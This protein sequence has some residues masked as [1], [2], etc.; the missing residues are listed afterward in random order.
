MSSLQFSELQGLKQ[1]NFYINNAL[2]HSKYIPVLNTIC[3]PNVVIWH[4]YILY[5][6]FSLVTLNSRGRITKADLCLLEPSNE[7][8]INRGR[9]ISNKSTADLHNLEW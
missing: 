2:R 4:Q 1:G 7:T 6:C 8:E 3:M 5:L 9:L